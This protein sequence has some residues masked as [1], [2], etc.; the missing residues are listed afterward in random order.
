MPKVN[1]PQKEGDITISVGGDDPRTYRVSEG[2]VTVAEKDVERFLAAV[3]GSKVAGGSTT[4]AT[5]KES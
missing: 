1:V 2:Q 5:K 3:D 4:A